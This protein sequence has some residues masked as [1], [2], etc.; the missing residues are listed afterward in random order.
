MRT[1]IIAC[2]I[3]DSTP[4]K[5]HHI[6]ELMSARRGKSIIGTRAYAHCLYHENLYARNLRII[7]NLGK[8]R[9]LTRENFYAY[10]MYDQAKSLHMH[11]LL[12]SPRLIN[13]HTLSARLSMY[14][15][16]LQQ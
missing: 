16:A 2:A 15:P 6:L 10:G 7:T 3:L 5:A 4:T 13:S 14:G 1:L 12:K 11:E 8:T 9:N